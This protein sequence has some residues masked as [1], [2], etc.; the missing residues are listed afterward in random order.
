MKKAGLIL[1]IIVTGILSGC[2]IADDFEDLFEPVL[3]YGQSALGGGSYNWPNGIN[4][5][6]QDAPFK[7]DSATYLGNTGLTLWTS[8]DYSKWEQA[9][10]GE[11]HVSYWDN[12]ALDP[13]GD[14]KEHSTEYLPDTS[15]NDLGEIFLVFPI[16][17][18]DLKPQTNYEF[19]LSLHLVSDFQTLDFLL[20]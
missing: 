8:F 10:S 11:I 15:I 3:I 17:I 5:P 13:V 7:L 9:T 19:C 6:Y 4:G 20:N 1:G 16:E 2:N 18:I 14:S 12:D